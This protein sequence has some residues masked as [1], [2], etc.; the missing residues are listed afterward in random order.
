MTGHDGELVIDGDHAMLRFER[1]L[2]HPIEAVWA[3]I[4]D[5]AQRRQWM[6]PTTIDPREGG[7]IETVATG[8]ALPLESK[9]MTG[10]I[11]VWD[12][13][14]VFAH[15]WLQPIVE[16][17]VVRYELSSDGK[18][19]VLRFTHSGL[20]V[21]NAQGF[22]PGTQAF[23]DRLTAHLA[24]DRPPNWAAR[25]RDIAGISHLEH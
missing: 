2:P 3:A 8:P 22:R 7:S 16:P 1:R 14:H 13:P 23:L 19:T 24:G 9:R 5:P 15:E 21:P 12:P 11:L 10:R 17:G 4:T 6:G 20:G 18:G 25:Y